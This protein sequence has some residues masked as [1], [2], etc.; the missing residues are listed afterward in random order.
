MTFDNKTT[1]TQRVHV[2]C[3]YSAMMSS[4]VGLRD[5]KESMINALLQEKVTELD[6]REAKGFATYLE[7]KADEIRKILKIK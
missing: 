5:F 2:R 7:D 6:K 3:M 1:V 4:M